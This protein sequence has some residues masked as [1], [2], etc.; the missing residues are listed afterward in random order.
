MKTKYQK[1]VN[2]WAFRVILPGDPSFHSRKLFGFQACGGERT[3]TKTPP[4]KVLTYFLVWIGFHVRR[5][6]FR[7]KL[8]HA[9]NLIA[10]REKASDMKG[11]QISANSEKDGKSNK[12]QKRD[13]RDNLTVDLPELV[14]P[15]LKLVGFYVGFRSRLDGHTRGISAIW[16]RRAL[17]K[18][19]IR[20][21]KYGHKA[22]FFPNQE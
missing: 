1:T 6:P 15:K 17:P 13:K 9:E 2:T 22:H 7:S 12:E 8:Q 14:P 18:G 5:T 20:E 16:R 11:Q 21:T 19:I 10:K 3:K 4:R